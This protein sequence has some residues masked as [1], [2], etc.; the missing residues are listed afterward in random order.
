MRHG[1]AFRGAFTMSEG[2]R[3]MKMPRQ[4]QGIHRGART[5]RQN[6]APELPGEVIRRIDAILRGACE[7][8]RETLYEHEVYDILNHI[9]LA[10]PRYAFIA[11][12]EQVDDAVLHPFNND[13]MLKVVSPSI[14]HKQQ[15]GGVKKVRHHDPLFIRFILDQME[16]EVLS[17]FKAPDLPEIRGFLIVEYIPHTQALGYEVLFGF[18]EDPA[19]GPVLTLSKGGDDAEFFARYYDPANL[20]LAPLTL[21]EALEMV[22]ALNIRHKFES[23]GRLEYL[24]YFAEAAS[25]LSRLAYHYSFVAENRPEF[26]ITA[27]DVNPFVITSDHRFVA[28]DGFARFHPGRRETKIVPPVNTDRLEGFFNP[29]GIAVIGVSSDPEK[30]SLGRNIAHQIHDLG[31]KDL[32]LVNPKG[33]NLRIDGV[34]YPLYPSLREVPHPVDLAVYAAPARAA[35]EFLR[36]IENKVE[37]ALIL[38]SGIPSEVDYA[39]YARQLDAAT[40]EGLRVIG[41]NCMGVFYAPDAESQGLNTLFIEEKRLDLGYSSAGNTVLLTQSGAFSV[42]AID[43]FQ[44][45]RLF[46]AIVSFGNKYDVKIPDLIAYFS[47]KPGIDLISL[48]I[49]GLDPGEGRGFF[50][51]VRRLSLPIIVYK[52]GKTDAGARIAASHTASMSGSYDVFRAACRQAGVILAENIEDHYDAVK[53]FSLLSRKPPS[54]NR[55]AGVVNA[56]FESAVGADELA[57]LTPAQLSPET[58]T[59]LRGLDA[60]GLV[61]TRSSFLDITPMADDRMYGDFVRRVLWDENVDCLFVSV[62]PHTDALKTLPENCRDPDSL[63]NRLV[64]IAGSSPKPIVVSVNAGRYYQ[65]FVNILEENGLPVYADIR[66]AIRSLDRFTAFHLSRRKQG[67]PKRFKNQ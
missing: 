58:I 24:T 59:A 47:K 42:T 45:S 67:R 32:Y 22:Q 52:S 49:E 48:Y 57:H 61:D 17:H 25:K 43:K 41:P 50:Q 62:I 65:D 28:V 64:A 51:L 13:L 27:L 9:G 46:K 35:P 15:L 23:I 60:G 2:Y 55:V 1:L 10:T 63:A 44:R 20:S 4:Q 53:A 56:G 54:G 5:E 26:I 18:K 31:R 7:D 3:R 33:G 37:K 39:E 12:P 8:L 11:S 19:F 40:P 29:R 30:H 14:A 16:K 38:I 6:D 21:E 34:D 36:T 66:S